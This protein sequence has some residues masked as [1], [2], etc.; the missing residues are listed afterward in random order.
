MIEIDTSQPVPEPRREP[1]FSI[2][3]KTYDA[4]VDFRA[5]QALSFVAIYATQGFMAAAD[6][7][8][9]EA[10][11][12]EGYAALANCEHLKPEQYEAILSQITKRLIGLVEAPKG[13]LGD[14]LSS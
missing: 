6:W 9:R 4:V 2:G 10:L 14:E 1:L 12:A 3:D 8:M 11:G 5:N 13:Q 7:A